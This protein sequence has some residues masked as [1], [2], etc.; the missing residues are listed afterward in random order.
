[1]R[2][3]T[4]NLDQLETALEYADYGAIEMRFSEEVSRDIIAAAIERGI[5]PHELILRA[6]TDDLYR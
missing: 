6:V 1:M 2:A 3:T 4:D 5:D